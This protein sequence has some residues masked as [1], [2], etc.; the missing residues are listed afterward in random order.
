MPSDPQT[1]SR[2]QDPG[3]RLR[4]VLLVFCDGPS[5]TFELPPE[6]T[7]SIGRGEVCDLRI[8]D[9]SVSY[10]HAR[11][12]IGESL[13]IE[14]EQSRNG[15]YVRGLR[16][17]RA[18]RVVLHTGDVIECGFAPLLLGQL[19]EPGKRG[20]DL[21]VGARAHWFQPPGGGRINL[22]RRGAA[23][24]VLW[25]LVEQRVLAPGVGLPVDDIVQA[26]W[27]RERMQHESGL[28]RAYVTIQ[29]LRALGLKDVLV[30]RDD[31]YLLDPEI[32]VERRD[33]A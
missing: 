25:R 3:G 30:T 28:A 27:P 17:D 13:T 23:R 18:M 15:T 32:N 7:I 6:G 1:E 20:A 9:R 16:L 4:T 10:R 11:L 31:G 8:E 19:A 12:H 22:G 29:R 14:D 21:L 33:G 26:G 5:R 24:R 2:D